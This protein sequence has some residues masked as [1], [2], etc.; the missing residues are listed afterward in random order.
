MPDSARD[1]K[2]NFMF[3]RVS[4]RSTL[5]EAWKFDDISD[6]LSKD[7]TAPR[8]AK[9]LE[10]LGLQ[11]EYPTEEELVCWGLSVSVVDNPISKNLKA[12]QNG[13]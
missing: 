6:R 13:G 4:N 8:G 1:W 2:A 5:S 10:K 3:F 7:W 9:R 11:S 12:K